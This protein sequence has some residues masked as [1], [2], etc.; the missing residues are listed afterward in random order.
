MNGYENK[1]KCLIIPVSRSGNNIRPKCTLKSDLSSA[2][3]ILVSLSW[4]VILNFYEKTYMKKTES[5]KMTSKFLYEII[6]R[7]YERFTYFSQ[8]WNLKIFKNTDV[9][10]QKSK[11]YEKLNFN[12]EK[13]QKCNLFFKGISYIKF[14]SNS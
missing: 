6:I 3:V 1:I 11:H 9:D 7:S 5:P 13:I 4:R 10:Q 12:R 2:F 14:K 8:T